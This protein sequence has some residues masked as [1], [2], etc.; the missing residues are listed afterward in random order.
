MAYYTGTKGFGNDVGGDASYLAQQFN[1]II[2]YDPPVSCA[3][4]WEY[5]T[6][7]LTI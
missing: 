4:R 3:L 6:V 5:L 1:T 2:D 7:D